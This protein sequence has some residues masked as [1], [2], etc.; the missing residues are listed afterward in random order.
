M[1]IIK[2]LECIDEKDYLECNPINRE[3][4]EDFLANS[5]EKSDRTIR[6]YKSNLRIWL[7]WV[8]ENLNNKLQTEIK[9][10]EY[11]RFQNWL[12]SLGHSSSDISNK[13]SAI[14]SF[15]DYIVVY[16]GDEYP[17][18]HNFINKSIKKP[19]TALVHEK[20]PPT[21]QEIE[22]II[23]NLENSKRKD[24]NQLIA[25]LKFTFET[26][27]RRAETRQ[28]LKDIVNTPLTIKEKKSKDENG[29][30]II[31]EI[32]YYLTPK[33]R[34]KGKG[35][36][37]KIRQ[38]KF[39]DYSMNAFKEWVNERTDDCPYMFVSRPFGNQIRQ[40]SETTLNNWCSKIIAPILG[41]RFHPHATREGIAT[42]IVTAQG[43]SIEAARALLGHESSETTKIY[44]C[45]VD[46]EE[47]ADE[48]F[49]E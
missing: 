38:L 4:L 22:S 48:L 42:D 37:G 40:A 13:R 24:K 31:K 17:T 1:I 39:S 45:G 19:E 6:V 29:N 3:L 2:R 43:K 33:I 28:I 5:T 32:K 46:E 16:Y 47:D 36:T 49:A 20:V 41:R 18:F 7:I 23:E 25:Y 15:N 27:C 44:V 26:G 8:K 30:E 9:P 11:L 34:C 14:S 10:R 21:R 35:K 12:I